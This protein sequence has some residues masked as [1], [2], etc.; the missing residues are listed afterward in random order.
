MIILKYKSKIMFNIYLGFPFKFHKWI[1]SS[2][3][4]F[5]WNLQS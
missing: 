5:N 1:I 2:S 4:V 3:H